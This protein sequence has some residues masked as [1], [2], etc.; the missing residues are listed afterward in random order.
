MLFYTVY[1]H[2]R[3]P[4]RIGSERRPRGKDPHPHIPPQTW[5]AHGQTPTLRL[6]K[7]P[8]QP[9]I[10]KVFKS[11]HSLHLAIGRFKDNTSRQST[12]ESALPRNTKLRLQ[13]RF[14]IGYRMNLHLGTKLQNLDKKL[15]FYRDFFVFSDFHCIFAENKD[16]YALQHETIYISIIPDTHHRLVPCR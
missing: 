9:K 3:E 13:R 1:A 2:T 6:C 11:A 10:I 7:F 14:E 5:R 8:N 4:K 16:N 15:K 12:D